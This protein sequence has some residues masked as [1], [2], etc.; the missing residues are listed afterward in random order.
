MPVYGVDLWVH[1]LSSDIEPYGAIIKPGIYESYIMPEL[2]QYAFCGLVN[3]VYDEA[4][5][6]GRLTLHTIPLV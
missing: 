2:K 3:E 1:S 5:G 6:S 4:L